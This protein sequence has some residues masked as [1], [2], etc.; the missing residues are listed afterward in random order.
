MRVWK[1]CGV[2]LGESAV[3]GEGSAGLEGVKCD[4]LITVKFDGGVNSKLPWSFRPEQASM[5]FRPGQ[6]YD[7]MFYARNDGKRTIVGNA[8]PSIAPADRK[9]TRLNSSH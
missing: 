6:Q 4:R 8:V 7:T 5:K 3:Y 2:G 1:V 9:S